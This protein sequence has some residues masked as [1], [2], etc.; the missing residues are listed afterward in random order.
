MLVIRLQLLTAFGTVVPGITRAVNW[1][2][3]FFDACAE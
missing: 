3:R 1:N 2:Q